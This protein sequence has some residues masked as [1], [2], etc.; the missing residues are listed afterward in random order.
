MK[1]TAANGK[2]MIALSGRID[3][4]NARTIDFEI[5]EAIRTHAG[6][7]VV[8]DAENLE[9]ISSAGL[10]IL[11]KLSKR[12]D[13]PIEVLNVSRDVYEIMEMTGF[14]ELLN[15]KKAY[16]KINI[17]GMELIGKGM[18]GNVY[19]ADKET[20]IKV[21][22][23]N[24]SF[25]M[26]IAQEN[27]KA[28]NAFISGVPT[29]IPYDIVRVGECYGTVY[30]LLN[31]KDLVSVIAEDKEHMDDYIRIFAQTV[32]KMHT[33]EVDPDKFQS[34]KVGSINALAYLSS[35][36]NEDEIRK[37][38]EL[39]ET[40]PDR[41]T[42]IHGDCHIGNAMFQDGELMLIDLATAGMGH[43][44][45]DMVSMYSLFVERANNPKAI[46]ES[47]ILC[48]FTKDEMIRV[49]N[50]FIRTYLNT[51]D[52]ELIHKAE[53]QINALSLAR[54]LFMV[55][56]VPGALKPEAIDAMKQ[57]I[58]AYYDSGMEPICF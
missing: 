7:Q 28:K 48:H 47:P 46:A 58:F 38:R 21:F 26:I 31:A 41:N 39:Y 23:P 8:I 2:L 25:D 54:R 36:L 32:Q 13:K 20:V 49:W 45:F 52:E 56:A 12:F 43:P 10:R 53:R 40:I 30:E 18:T 3:T 6:S 9:Y 35:V 37:V 11:L 1:I 15:I 51:D 55:V 4:G 5:E 24:I 22:N 44:I 42:F 33:I 19:R 50:V 14:T 17:D 29:A 57:T 27:Q 16:R 34:T